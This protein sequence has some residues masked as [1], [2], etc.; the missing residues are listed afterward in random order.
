M[1]LSPSDWLCLTKMQT[2]YSTAAQSIPS[3]ASVVSI[4]LAPDIMSAFMNTLDIQNFGALKLITFLKEIPEFEQLDEHDR[5]ILVKYNL[6]PLMVIRELFTFD[7]AREICYDLDSMDN[8]SP[9]DEAFA[10]HCKSL[11]ILCYGYEFNQT[12]I[13]VLNA[14]EKLVNKNAIT[15]QLLMLIVIFSKGLSADENQE[16]I[17]ND[18]K[19]VF[20]AQSKYLELLF[21]YLMENSSYESVVIKMMRFIEQLFKIQK[22]LRDFQQQIKTKIDVTSINPLMKSLLH[23]T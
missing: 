16:P 12:I 21:R 5:L 11:F 13:S 19:S 1:L 22:F 7:S 23:F 15:I 18:E 10:H 8:I 14:L 6:T 20:K 2:A 4:E 9:T 3:A 17:L